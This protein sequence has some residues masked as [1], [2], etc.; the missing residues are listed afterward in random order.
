METKKILQ[1]VYQHNNVTAELLFKC[2]VICHDVIPMQVK[3]KTVM[4][5]T[6]QDELIVLDVSAQSL[7]FTLVK[8]DS[9]AIVI[10]DNQSGEEIEIHVMKT[11]EFTS[12]RKMM[13]VIVRMN[14]KMYSFTKGADTS[15]EPLLV[16]LDESDKMS[17]DD[18][19]D[20]A[21]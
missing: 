11:F 5:G 7:Y 19:D 6:S 1:Q 12:E 8:R 10:K 18:L 13:T 17:L 16:G 4:S 14:D 15:M 21:E 9:E 3:G 20:F 2:F